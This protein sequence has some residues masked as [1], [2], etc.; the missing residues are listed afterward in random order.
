[1]LYLDV[2]LIDYIL[3]YLDPLGAL[4]LLVVAD[5]PGL[6]LQAPLADGGG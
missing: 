3:Y 4:V 2:L 1:M 5:F 6:P